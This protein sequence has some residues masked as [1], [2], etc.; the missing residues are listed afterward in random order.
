MG[1]HGN[2]CFMCPRLVLQRME[3]AMAHDQ[4]SIPYVKTQES[5]SMSLFS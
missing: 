5:A 4:N 1:M 2:G 3:R